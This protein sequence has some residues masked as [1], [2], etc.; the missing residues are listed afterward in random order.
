MSTVT[1]IELEISFNI[2]ICCNLFP[3]ITSRVMKVLIENRSNQTGGGEGDEGRGRFRISS[4][5]FCTTAGDEFVS[6]PERTNRDRRFK[7]MFSL[8]A[9]LGNKRCTEVD[10][11]LF[12]CDINQI[13]RIVTCFN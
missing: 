10:Q 4:I 12:Q 7:L 13:C 1:T 9:K 11:S 3:A 2:S 5:N 8:A 6:R